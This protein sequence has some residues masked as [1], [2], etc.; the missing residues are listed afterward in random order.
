MS[1]KTAIE[2]TE[3]TWNPVRGCTKVSPGC[4]NCYAETFAERFRGVPGHPYEQGFDVR[5]VHDA[6]YLPLR[7]RKPRQVFTNSMSDLF[8]DDVPTDFIAWMFAVM[9]L[10]RQHTFQCLTKRAERMRRLLGD[11]AFWHEVS[12]AIDMT[13]EDEDSPVGPG[14]GWNGLER[15]SD[16]ARA[17]APAPDGSEPLPNVW[18]GVS[19]ENQA[20]AD[21]RVPE[22][23]S[24]PAAVR[25]LSCEPLLGPVDLTRV[26]AFRPP[27]WPTSLSG[28][29][30]TYLDALRGEGLRPSWTGVS[31]ETSVP[32]RLGWVIA[33]GESGPG[34]RACDVAWIRSIVEQCRAA[35]V[36]AFVKQLGAHVEDRNDA[37]FEGDTSTSWPMDTDVEHDESDTGYQGAPVR[38]RLRDRKGGDMAEWP[39]DLRVRQMPEAA[40]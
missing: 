18:L 24:T 3:S 7:W 23:L 39:E 4:K 12:C 19:V 5:L 33:G 30:K 31:I 25:F 2:W 22:L 14:R 15:R 36:P 8:H 9:A 32:N 38:V 1:T 6:L 20:A 26:D 28:E 10:A 34:S 17:T 13:L 11:K 16:D 35:R 37:G 21:E 27:T 29:P 40:R